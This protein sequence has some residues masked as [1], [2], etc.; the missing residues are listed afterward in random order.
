M[1]SEN[2]ALHILQCERFVGI[3]VQER[4]DCLARDFVQDMAAIL[5]DAGA[6]VDPVF[7]LA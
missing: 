5:T 1:A 6:V 7:R 2:V 3:S 4:V